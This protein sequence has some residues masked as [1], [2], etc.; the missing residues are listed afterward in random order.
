M[1]D[2]WKS[3]RHVSV[4]RVYRENA[5]IETKEVKGGHEQ[6]NRTFYDSGGKMFRQIHTGAH[7]NPKDHPYGKNG[8]HKHEYIWNDD[9]T[10]KTRT[11]G[12]LSEADRK[13]NSD[14]L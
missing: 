9:G 11:T 3:K 13:E 14:I 4:P 12:E 2:N 6:I 5:I 1:T 8:E 7:S 10:L